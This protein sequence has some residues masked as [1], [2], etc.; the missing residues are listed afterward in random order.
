MAKK[1]KSNK[2]GGV[3]HQS[4]QKYLLSGAARRLD[5]GVCYVSENLEENCEGIVVVSRKHNGGRVS[6]AAFLLDTYCLGVKDTY[7]NLRME[8]EDFDDFIDG[9]NDQIGITECSYDEAHN[10]VWGAVAW[11]EEGGI[12]PHKNFALTQ[13]MLDED[14]DDVPLIDLPFGRDGKHL[15]MANSIDEL[16]KYMP[17]LRERLG[18]DVDFTLPPP[19][20][21]KMSNSP[22]FKKYGPDSVYTYRHPDY[23]TSME[24]RSPR[25]VFDALMSTERFTTI[26]PT[27]LDRMLQ[28]PHDDLRHDLEQILLY[29]IGL[30]CD[31]IPEDYDP[32]GFSGVVDKAVILLGEV[33]DPDTSLDVVLEVL[34]Q[35]Q[36]FFDYH[37][38]DISTE[39][40]APTLYKLGRNRLD[41]LMEFAKEEGLYSFA[42][43]HAF[44]APAYVAH[45]E[46]ERRREVLDWFR[47]ILLFATRELP[48]T[49][50]FDSALSGL[51]M[52]RLFDIGARELLPE[53]KVMFG[54]GLVDIRACGDYNTVAKDIGKEKDLNYK[55]NPL[56]IHERFDKLRWWEEREEK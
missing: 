16:Q 48:N 39:V 1:K 46:P 6:F 22:M 33:G 56:D 14:T 34:R 54:T 25:W 42:K 29:H 36:V 4:P 37:H 15:L 23:P 49:Q 32:Y 30:T 50:R 27:R 41:K 19:D 5:K 3:Q 10:W 55:F 17:I 24:L 12:G 9:M 40:F 52:F 35:N 13:M 20:F 38:G 28:L 7:F 21:D 53:I 31:G 44:D 51:L 47:E 11:A 8:P 45:F 2:A 18:D 26:E 43:C